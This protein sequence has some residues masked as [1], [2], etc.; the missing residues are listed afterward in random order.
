MAVTGSD[1]RR[2]RVELVWIRFQL[3]AG[4]AGLS[5]RE[6]RNIEIDFKFNDSVTPEDQKHAMAVMKQQIAGLNVLL[7]QCCDQFKINCDTYAIFDPGVFNKKKS[8]GSPPSTNGYDTE[9]PRDKDA[10]EADI[11]SIGKDMAIPVILTNG[12]RGGQLNNG[13]SAG[14]GRSRVGAALDIA[15]IEPDLPRHADILAHGLGHAVGYEVE[16]PK[17]WSSK[18]Q[19]GKDH[20]KDPGE[21]IPYNDRP[22]MSVSGGGT[23]DECW[24]RKMS[25]YSVPF[26]QIIIR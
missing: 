24:C 15:K 16:D 6:P 12:D 26:P 25:K 22:L 2:R 5:G 20:K 21:N 19:G 9:Q 8:T 17:E 18:E 1:W 11:G 3:A 23:V 14:V 10:L 7:K 13:K 4:L